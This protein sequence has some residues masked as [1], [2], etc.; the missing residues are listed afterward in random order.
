MGSGLLTANHY[1]SMAGSGQ[2]IDGGSVAGKGSAQKDRIDGAVKKF[3][4]PRVMGGFA[5]GEIYIRQSGRDIV[6]RSPGDRQAFTTEQTIKE[7]CLPRGFGVDLSEFAPD[8]CLQPSMALGDSGNLRSFRE[9][10][11]PTGDIAKKIPKGGFLIFGK[12]EA[13]Q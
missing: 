11:Q 4:I 8:L 12:F 7:C 10:G 13:G 6:S 1:A 3:D 5:I 9:S 2:W